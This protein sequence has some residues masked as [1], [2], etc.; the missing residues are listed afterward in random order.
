MPKVATNPLL[1]QNC[2]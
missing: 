2:N 1:F